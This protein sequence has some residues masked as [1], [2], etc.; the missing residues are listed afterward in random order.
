MEI[1][2][3]L[4]RAGAELEHQDKNGDS[5]LHYA[6]D[7]KSTEGLLKCGSEIHA[8]NDKGET[9]LHKAVQRRSLPQA[10]LLIKQ[11]AKVDAVDKLGRT[12]LFFAHNTDMVD[13]LIDSGADVNH[14]DKNEQT[15]IKR[16]TVKGAIKRMQRAGAE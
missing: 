8:L 3:A 5:P 1:I 7:F 15:P 2:N 14:R 11:D 13:L 6:N 12:P 10:R 9:P 16:M 4:L